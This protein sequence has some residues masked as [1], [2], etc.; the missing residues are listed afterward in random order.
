MNMREKCQIIEAQQ[1]SIK[2]RN[3]FCLPKEE[4]SEARE[5]K[6]QKAKKIFVDDD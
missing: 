1:I 5:I 3:L 2:G 4:K 6:N